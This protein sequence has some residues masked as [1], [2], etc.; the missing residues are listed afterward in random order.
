MPQDK[1]KKLTDRVWTVPNLLSVLRIL[2]VP[3]FAVL[4]LQGHVVGAVVLL[5]ASGVTDMLDGLI[6][7]RFN[8][9][10]DLGKMLD[11][12]ADKLTQ[13]VVALCIAIR[14]SAVRPLLVLFMLKELLMLCC[15]LVLLKKHKRPCAAKWYGKVA[16]VMFYVSVSAIVAMDGLGIMRPDAFNLAALAMLG[17]TALMMA[18]AAVKYF[19]IF[20]SI[21]REPEER[22]E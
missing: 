14:F 2:I 7:R 19:Q 21:L 17:V 6:A 12:F 13:G 15:A 8:Q 20:L 9:I 18:Y 16:T 22:E 4:Y 11:P 1:E 3:F 5:A 10:S